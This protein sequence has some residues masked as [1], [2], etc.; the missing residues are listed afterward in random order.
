MKDKTQIFKIAYFIEAKTYSKAARVK[1]AYLVIKNDTVKILLSDGNID[2]ERIYQVYLTRS[3]LGRVIKINNGTDYVFIC[4][5]W[6]WITGLFMIK[7][8]IKTKKLYKILSSKALVSDIAPVSTQ[9]Y[10]PRV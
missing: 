10:Q 3:V 8:T 1:S 4:V 7:N 9:Y 2:L 6:I 5:I